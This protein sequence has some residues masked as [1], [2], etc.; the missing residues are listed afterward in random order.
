MADPDFPNRLFEQGRSV[1]ARFGYREAGGDR[2]DWDRVW[3]LLI[4]DF[5]SRRRRIPR[6]ADLTAEQRPAALEYMRL[7]LVADRNVEVCEQLHYS[8]F[9]KGIDTDL[10][11][12]YAAAREVY[13]DSVEDFG[14]ARERLDAMFPD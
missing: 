9:A 5:P 11:E 14:R 8:L 3:D 1:L 13:E 2:D 7:R 4:G 12:R 10:V 6:F